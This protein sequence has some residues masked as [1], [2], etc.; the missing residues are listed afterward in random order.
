MKE[1]QLETPLEGSLEANVPARTLQELARIA[2]A[3]ETDSIE[4]AALE[5][6]VVFT[7]DDVVLSSRLVE[8]RFPNYQ[9]L[10]AAHAQLVLVRLGQQLL[11]VREATF[12]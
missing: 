11:V 5:N 3:A 12:D 8:G 2:G 7:V 9:Q 10:I 4:V 1:T 6:Q